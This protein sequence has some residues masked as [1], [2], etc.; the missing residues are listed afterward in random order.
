MAFQW[1]DRLSFQR[2]VGL[3]DSSLIPDRTTIKIAPS[4]CRNRKYVYAC[5]MAYS[6]EIRTD[7]MS[8]C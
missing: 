7:D 4:L 1:L 5:L 3:R 8:F 6:A 2:V